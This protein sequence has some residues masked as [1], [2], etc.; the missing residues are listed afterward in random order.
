MRLLE[1]YYLVNEGFAKDMNLRII[2]SS[3]HFTKDSKRFDESLSS[4]EKYFWHI[5]TAIKIFHL[6]HRPG[7]LGQNHL[8]DREKFLMPQQRLLVIEAQKKC[9]QNKI[10]WGLFNNGLLINSGRLNM[11]LLVKTHLFNTKK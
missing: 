1:S 6:L 4:W 2:T 7:V 3:I 9:V 10:S 5:F 11:T 8:L